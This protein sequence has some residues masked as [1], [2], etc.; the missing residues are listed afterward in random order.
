MK[1]GDLRPNLPFQL[2][3]ADGVTPLDVSTATSV[4]IVVRAKGG[5]LK[6]KA[7]CDLTDA[8]EGEGIYDW[9][10][11]DTDTAGAFEYEFEILW[12][13]GSPQTVPVDK[14][15]DLTIVDDIG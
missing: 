5:A 6:F 3:Q 4:S 9:V 1:Q 14:Y 7:E 8:A 2:F 15:L 10:E 12:N 13:D 11:G